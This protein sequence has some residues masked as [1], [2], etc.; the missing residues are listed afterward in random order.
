MSHRNSDPNGFDL[1]A[2]DAMSCKFKP[3]LLFLPTG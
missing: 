2:G 1:D 3:T